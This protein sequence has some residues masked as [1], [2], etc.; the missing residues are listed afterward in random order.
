MKSATKNI[1]A[2]EVYD[3]SGSL[4]RSLKPNQEEVK[5]EANN[6]VNDPYVLKIDRNG[7]ITTKKVIK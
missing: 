2:L 6:F 4:L 1:T 5:N 3:I 7:E